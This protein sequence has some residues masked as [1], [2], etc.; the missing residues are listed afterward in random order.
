MRASRS[1]VV[2]G[3]A[4]GCVAATVVGYNGQE[5]SES[6]E[7]QDL[8]KVSRETGSGLAAAARDSR[9]DM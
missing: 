9:N 6:R 3:G 8:L 4:A 7:R 2:L 1:G 5:L